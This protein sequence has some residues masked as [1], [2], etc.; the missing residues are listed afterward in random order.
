MGNILPIAGKKKSAM[1]IYYLTNLPH[2]DE[3]D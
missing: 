2:K 3:P 1:A